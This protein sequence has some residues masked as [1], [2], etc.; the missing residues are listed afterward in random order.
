MTVRSK[1]GMAEKAISKMCIYIGVWI[2]DVAYISEVAKE[3]VT[4][5][6][7]IFEKFG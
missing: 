5:L 2:H 1:V 3:Y 6:E 7:N 4:V